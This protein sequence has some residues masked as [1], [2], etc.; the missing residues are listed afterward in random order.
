[1]AFWNPQSCQ[2]GA[3]A[4]TASTK[5]AYTNATLTRLTFA[6]GSVSALA[7]TEEAS[8]ATI[9][10]QRKDTDDICADI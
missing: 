4:P 1:M 9:A 8:E 2:N 10:M 5:S 3:A 7:A 6:E